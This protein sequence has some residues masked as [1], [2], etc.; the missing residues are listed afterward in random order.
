MLLTL[1]LII[2]IIGAIIIA[3]VPRDRADIVRW[4]TL[5]TTLVALAVTPTLT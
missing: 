1:L 3:F 5:A 4:L 2:P